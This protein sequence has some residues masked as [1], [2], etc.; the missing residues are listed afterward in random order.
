MAYIFLEWIYSCQ[1]E[2]NLILLVL[3]VGLCLF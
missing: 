1:V 2:Q 3:Y